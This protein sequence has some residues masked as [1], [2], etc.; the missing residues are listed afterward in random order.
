MI[1]KIVFYFSILLFICQTT[2]TCY[3]L[4]LVPKSD[5]T[6]FTNTG[7]KPGAI[8]ISLGLGFPVPTTQN[9]SS[10]LYSKSQLESNAVKGFGPLHFRGEWFVIRRF[11]L[12]FSVNYS[13]LRGQ[14][15]NSN[16]LQPGIQHIQY[17][18]LTILP[19]LNYHF[20]FRKK[21]DLYIGLGFGY[22]QSS[23]KISDNQKFSDKNGATYSGIGGFES[24]VGIRY[25]VKGILGTYLEAGLGLS[26][27]QA[28]ICV[29]LNRW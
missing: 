1:N 9:F 19:R 2:I 24:V 29:N 27:L 26:L 16:P 17:S 28:G 4:H 10:Y 8:I 23:I 3:G 20:L 15:K 21:V 7:W 25:L 12:G 5:T 22:Y 18:N 14:I 11:G 13:S 6:K